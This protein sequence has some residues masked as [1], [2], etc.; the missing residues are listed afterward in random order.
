MSP[1]S[2]FGGKGGHLRS[3][4]HAGSPRWRAGGAHL[5]TWVPP[6]PHG[7]QHWPEGHPACGGRAQSPIDIRRQ[8]V[9]LDPSLPP[10]RPVGYQRP[11]TPA[12]T[13]ANNGHTGEREPGGPWQGSD[14]PSRAQC[15]PCV[16]APQ[17]CWCCRPPCGSRGCPGASPPLSSISTGAGPATPAAL[18][19]SWTGTAP[20]PRYGAT[21]SAGSKRG[22]GLGKGMGVGN[23]AGMG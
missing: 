13:L 20:P 7:Q 15:P 17:R 19:T 14:V 4:S 10:V 23:G 6:G 5:D 9:Q 1:V 11:G 3:R 8:R 21:P 18:S 2:S 16:P 22:S 12:F